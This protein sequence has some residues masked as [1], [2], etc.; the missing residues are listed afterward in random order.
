MFEHCT[1][2]KIKDGYSNRN[3]S[4][5]F[6][7]I[8]ERK[9]WDSLSDEVK[10]AVLSNAKRYEDYEL[11]V[12]TLSMYMDYFKTGGRQ[13]YESPNFER[14]EALSALT[15]AECIENK[16][17]YLPKIADILWAICEESTWSAPSHNYVLPDN[18]DVHVGCLPD[19]DKQIFDLFASET[20]ALLAWVLYLLR[21]KLDEIS[22]LLARRV[23]KELQTRI[24]RPY[25][26]CDTYLWMLYVLYD[27]VLINNWTPWC[28]SNALMTLL[29]TENDE[30]KCVKGIEKALFS[31]EKFVATYPE[32]GGC[33]EGPG[34]WNKAAGSLF[35][36]LY[37][38]WMVSGGV[39]NLFENN[40]KLKKM[41]GYIADVHI[42]EDHF[43]SY[44]DG[45]EKC[46]FMPQKVYQFGKM[47]DNPSMISLAVELY[48]SMPTPVPLQWNMFNY[49]QGVFLCDELAAEPERPK[50]LEDVYLK[51][52]NIVCFR[53]ENGFFFSAKGG[54]NGESHNHTDVGN[55]VVY[56]KNTPIVVDMGVGNYTSRHW[57]A[58]RYKVM[59]QRTAYHNLPMVNG[60]EQA[61]GEEFAAREMRYFTE[62]D[63]SYVTM[64][65]VGAYPAK[66]GIHSWQRTCGLIRGK[67]V[68]VEEKGE[69]AVSSE[70]EYH[71]ITPQ[72]PVLC[73]EGVILGS[74]V[75][76]Y[77]INNFVCEWEELE[78]DIRLQGV[79]QNGLYRI[80]LKCK[81]KYKT[82]YEKFV[83]LPI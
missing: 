9:K 79:W 59:T 19:P 41:A 11:H 28:T 44:A 23:E 13:T 75:L 68:Q 14:R 8:E 65:I 2:K 31:L 71:F 12:L 5:L 33:D 24:I 70:I 35:D 74:A 80:T 27:G 55:F 26:E 51:D 66:A 81:E 6:P 17:E 16:G 37:L 76:C 45:D 60:Y 49:L 38:L 50:S 4:K 48:R 18:A 7:T 82:L 64:D 22:P 20:G 1:L 77:D 15:V 39:L 57:G 25:L 78:L 47:T 72:Q 61:P 36:C 10:R 62:G 58:E 43:V 67:M 54:H 73:A 42:Y 83:F 34:Y 21:K 29:L 46:G 69:F 30:E 32:D 52:L 40:P 53:E 63:S 3:T 56:Y